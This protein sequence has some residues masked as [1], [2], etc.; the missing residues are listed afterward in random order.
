MHLLI[1]DHFC[2]FIFYLLF[3]FF[4]VWPFSLAGQ[5]TWVPLVYSISFAFA[6]GISSIFNLSS[7]YFATLFDM[8]MKF[9][10]QWLKVKIDEKKVWPIYPISANENRIAHHFQLTILLSF[11]PFIYFQCATIFL[12]RKVKFN[13]RSHPNMRWFSF[14]FDGISGSCSCIN[15]CSR[16]SFLC[17]KCFVCLQS[18]WNLWPYHALNMTGILWK[19]EINLWNSFFFIPILFVDQFE[20]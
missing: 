2:V 3:D 13:I 14:E 12:W 7:I 19:T 4:F 8:L 1:L 11:E 5:L 6:V 20:Q 17:V 15:W 18:F 9:T 16:F 10:W